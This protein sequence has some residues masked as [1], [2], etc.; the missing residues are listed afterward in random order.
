MR[1]LDLDSDQRKRAPRNDSRFDSPGW[2]VTADAGVQMHI[3][4]AIGRSPRGRQERVHLDIHVNPDRKNADVERLTGLGVT[5]GDN[6]V[7]HVMRS[8]LLHRGPDQPRYRG[9]LCALDRR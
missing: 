1:K 3:V 9:Y 6:R 7:E 2:L 4:A 5:P 8:G